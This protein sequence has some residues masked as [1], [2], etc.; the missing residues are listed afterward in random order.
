MRAAQ[1]KHL[2]GISEA[3]SSTLVTAGGG[4]K[5]ARQRGQQDDEQDGRAPRRLSRGGEGAGQHG[6]TGNGC[7]GEAEMA[8]HGHEQRP[9]GLAEDA[10]AVAYDARYVEDEGYEGLGRAHGGLVSSGLSAVSASAA[11][12]GLVWPGGTL[13][14]TGNVSSRTWVQTADAAPGRHARSVLV[15][16]ASTPTMTPGTSTEMRRTQ[17]YALTRRLRTA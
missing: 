5:N 2:Q 6:E 15:H 12:P 11:W 1:D 3:A 9:E 17:L 13:R 4:Q 7:G 8:G 14:T 16:Q 10:E